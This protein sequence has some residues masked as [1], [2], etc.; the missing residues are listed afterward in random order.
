MTDDEYQL[1]PFE[2]GW[3]CEYWN[4]I[5]HYSPRYHAV[6]TT[7]AVAP[8][9]VDTDCMLRQPA[10]SDIEA[11][12]PTY[13]A[14]FS[15]T[16]EYFGYSQ[17]QIAEAARR[18]IKNYFAGGHGRPT[19]ASCLAVD[20]KPYPGDSNPEEETI[21]GA[22][23]VTSTEDGPL[24]YLLFVAPQFQRRGLAT[25][26]VSAA[27]N[28]LH[29]LGE[30]TLTSRYHIGNEQSLNW[31]QRFGFVEEPDLRRAQLYLQQARVEL[32]RREQIGPL[33]AEEREKLTEVIA[34]W[35]SEVVNLETIEDQYGFDA[36][37]PMTRW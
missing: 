16:I 18:D 19:S 20:S 28:E 32:W 13:I 9:D 2:P 26:M 33:T 21:A 7:L 30:K 22:A 3:K 8:R 1:L 35:E 25:A 4:G 11:L 34:R 23:M 24:L 5:A 27:V 37:H 14:A 29:E 6:V 36:V 15:G 17:G 10:E 12:T 31:H